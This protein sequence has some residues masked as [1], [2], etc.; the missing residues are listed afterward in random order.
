MTLNTATEV[1][2]LSRK[3]EEESTSF[4][5]ALAQRH[6]E[7]SERF[8]SFAKENKKYMQ[9][10]ERVY[11]GVITDAFE[12]G[13]AFRIEPDDYRISTKLQ[14][15]ISLAE[16]IATAIKIEEKLRK[17]YTD[18]AEQSKSLLADIPRTFAQIVRKRQSRIEGLRAMVSRD[19]NCP[20]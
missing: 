6:P 17:F 2:S 8:L 10:V 18:S 20:R 4:Y 9:E 7:L 1:I 16:G 13:F 15:G 14:E 3:L 11:Y 12:G 5:Q 19:S